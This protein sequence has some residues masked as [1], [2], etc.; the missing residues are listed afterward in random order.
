MIEVPFDPEEAINDA[1]E[2]LAE[3]GVEKLPASLKAAH[4]RVA[5]RAGEICTTLA[6]FMVDGVLHTAVA[7]ADWH[8]AFDEAVDETLDA[9]RADAETQGQAGAKAANAEIA[10]KAAILAAHPSFNFSRVS[11]DKR[12]T[13]AEALFKDCDDQELREVTRVAENL[14]WLEQSGF[15]S[16]G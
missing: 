2:S 6:A 14:F 7:S 10:A 11:F 9:A 13:L 15:T 5:D 1:A 3:L 8:D 12:L 16:R 4:R